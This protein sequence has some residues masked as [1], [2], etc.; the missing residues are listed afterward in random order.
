MEQTKKF[1]LNG[2]LYTASEYFDAL[3]DEKKCKTSYFSS[4][5]SYGAT[6]YK[7]YEENNYSSNLRSSSYESNSYA[8]GANI[9]FDVN[10]IGAS[11]VKIGSKGVYY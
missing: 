11:F 9:P 7:S 4:Y 6:N 5:S 2:K 1:L 3:A 10:K 8:S